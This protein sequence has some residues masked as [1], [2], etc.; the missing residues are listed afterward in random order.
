MTS[1]TAPEGTVFFTGTDIGFPEHSP[2]D[3]DNEINVGWAIASVTGSLGYQFPDSKKAI[4][5]SY[6]ITTR[7]EN[8][9][10]RAPKSWQFQGS[11]DGTNWTTLD[12]RTNIT[13]WASVAPQSHSYSFSNTTEYQYYRVNITA[14]NDAS[15]VGIGL[16]TMDGTVVI[17]N[18]GNFLLFF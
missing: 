12:T 7:N 5:T 3:G 13:D 4:V 18:K 16:L 6:V 14:S 1:N 8:G 11:N 2:F 9:S 10:P 17:Q 15:Y